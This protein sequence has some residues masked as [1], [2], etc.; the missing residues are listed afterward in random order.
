LDSTKDKVSIVIPV[1]NGVD[2]LRESIDSVLNQTYQNIEVIIVDDGSTDNSLDVLKKYSDRINIIS[3]PNQGLTTALNIGIEHAHGKWFKWF[4]PDDILYPEAIETLVKIGNS[5]SQDTII[6]SNWEMIDEDGKKLRNFSE[7][8][9]NKLDSFDFNIRL[10][11]GQQ[12]NVN[13]TLIPIS[14]VKKCGFYDLE[15]SVAIDYD[16]FLRAGILYQAKFF[17]IEKNLVKYRINKNQ[18]SHRNISKTLLY[19]DKV[20]NNI[21]TELD[22]NIKKEYL[23]SLNQYKNNKPFSSKTKELGLIFLTK[24]LPISISDSILRFY[25]NKIRTHR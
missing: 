4:S 18:I 17:L 15:D 3:Q 7:S 16:F 9:Y 14:L 25:L 22:S 24:I 6:Y 19:L 21:L 2:F 10:L 11:D 12:I 20:R 8:N 1:Y 23:L 5:F 13:T